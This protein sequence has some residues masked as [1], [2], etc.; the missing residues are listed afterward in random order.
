MVVAPFPWIVWLELL[1]TE[2]VLEGCTWIFLVSALWL[3]LTCSQG[4]VNLF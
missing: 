1:S 3:P 4:S 2:L